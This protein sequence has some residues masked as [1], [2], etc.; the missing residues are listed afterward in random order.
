MLYAVMDTPL[1]SLTVAST[2]RGLSLSDFGTR[3]PRDGIIEESTNRVFM[4]QLDE[5]FRGKRT[6]FEF[7]LD[8]N[9]TPFQMAVW[10]ELLKIPYGET[11]TY[12]QIAHILGKPGAARA[13]GMANH[14]NR[15]AVVIPCHRVIGQDGSMTGYAGGIHLKERLLAIETP[16]LFKSKTT[17]A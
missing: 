15:I 2:C 9:G 8:I 3:V 17:G 14:V 11:R 16:T 12:G 13:V 4:Q 1:G 7:P 6:R 10:R 5:Y